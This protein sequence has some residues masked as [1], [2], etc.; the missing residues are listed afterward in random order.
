MDKPASTAE[1]TYTEED[2]T[3]ILKSWSI[4]WNSTLVLLED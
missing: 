3:A 4:L 2:A 1:E